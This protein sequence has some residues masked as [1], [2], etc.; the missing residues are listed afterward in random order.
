MLDDVPSIMEGRKPVEPRSKSLSDEGSTTGMVSAGS[1][2]N[3]S[4][5]G[6]SV[7]LCYAPLENPCSAA[8][9]EFSVDY[10]E[11]LGAP[12]DL[13]TMDRVFW[14]FASRQVGQVR[15]RPDRFDE[16]DFGRF[17]GEVFCSRC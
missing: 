9:V 5:E 10:R 11:G 4:K 3:L 8:L 16:H 15:L 17:L 1:F 13:S 7:F 2:M 6:D 12:H 14:E